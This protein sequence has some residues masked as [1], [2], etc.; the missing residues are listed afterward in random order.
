MGTSR[1]D[2][3]LATP[4]GNAKN[5]FLYIQEVGSLE[6]IE[7]HI[8]TRQ[9][10]TSY[11]FFIVTS[12]RGTL[13]YGKQILPLE[14]GDCVWIDCRKQYAHE[15]SISQ[16]W[17]LTWVHFNGNQAE[18][19]YR[20]FQ[21]QGGHF[22]FRPYDITP[23]TN[24]ISSIYHIQKEQSPLMEMETHKFLTDLILHC[25]QENRSNDF[26]T[27]SIHSKLQQVQTY[28]EAHASEKITLDHLSEIFFISKYHLSREYKST[29]GITI[30][31]AINSRRISCA[32]SLLRFT[33]DP[34][35]QICV[36]SGFQ[37]SA[38]FIK[39]FK[40]AEGMTPLEYRKKW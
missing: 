16:P 3:I 27:N 18:Y 30:G 13:T 6:S 9:N 32:K 1:S 7:P 8:S 29:F 37:D 4:T 17:T 5:H 28:I 31:N 2:R 36:A 38:Y 40:R 12:G 14:V 23:F 20:Y 22:V 39:V 35:E 24:C 33:K 21:E 15:S 25:F 34:I 10:L 26:G 19:Y 11:L